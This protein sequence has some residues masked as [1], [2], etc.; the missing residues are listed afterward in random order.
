M[1]TRLRGLRWAVPGA[2]ASAL[3]LAS[4]AGAN[5]AGTFNIGHG[6]NTPPGEVNTLSCSFTSNPCLD[7]ADSSAATAGPP[8]MA[9]R[10]RHSGPTGAGMGLFGVS[11]SPNGNGVFGT[12]NATTGTAAG[13]VGSTS[14]TATAAAGVRGFADGAGSDVMGVLGTSTS[15]MGV[16]AIGGGIGLFAYSANLAAYLNGFVFVQGNMHVQGTLS[17]SAGSFRIDHP[18]EPETKYLQHSFV[19]SPDMMNVYNGN[20]RTDR[21][22]FATVR[23]PRYFRALNRDFRYQ[24]TIVGT[25]GWRARVVRRI[26]GNRFTVQTDVPRALVSWQVTGIRKD[27]YAKANRI[28]PEVA[29]SAVDAV[30]VPSARLLRAMRAHPAR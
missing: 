27:A 5:H 11:E 28:R 24:L 30:R 14:S 18:L 13:V 15:G 6:H 21:R 23:L 29:K 19:E 1:K 4:A 3:V 17:K 22:G 12:H 8:V 20:V 2:L 9:I 10:G 25:R 16:A 26:S 7:V